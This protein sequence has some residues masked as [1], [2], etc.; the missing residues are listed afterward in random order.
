MNPH[1]EDDD[2]NIATLEKPAARVMRPQAK[3]ARA[4]VHTSWG[5]EEE[6]PTGFKKWRAPLIVAVLTIAVIG[7]AVKTLSKADSRGLKKDNM[8]MV[9]LHLPPAPP[10][11]PPPP[12]PPETMKEE[13]MIEAEKEEEAPPDPTP[14]VDTAIKGP[15][16]GPIPVAA[17]N[18][19]VFGNRQSGMST[20]A[21]WYAYASKVQ[22]RIAEALRNHRRTRNANARIVVRIWPDT[23]GRITR[24]Q[25]A[26]STSDPAMDAAIKDEV[27]TGLQL[28][29]PPPPGMP[30]PMVLRV[31]ARR[32]N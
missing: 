12:P 8:A 30:M 10:P 24:A 2:G 32:P 18:R 5:D 9:Q 16:A 3:P 26:S 14:A 20:K 4:P 13:K 29:E 17:G 21:R 7:V 11:P 23:T 15:G 31:T 6:T 22:A 25:L 28:Q 19:G 27:L 1:N